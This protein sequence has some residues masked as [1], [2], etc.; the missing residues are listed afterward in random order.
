MP[1]IPGSQPV[2][3]L[4]KNTE[5]LSKYDFANLLFYQYT[6]ALS[7]HLTSANTTPSTPI[8]G[9]QGTGQ[10]LESILHLDI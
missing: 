6:T 7:P 9:W 5:I 3:G 1:G 2:D 10:V 8:M 4:L